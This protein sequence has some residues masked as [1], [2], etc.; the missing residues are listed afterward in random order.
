MKVIVFG[1]LAVAAIAQSHVIPLQ[2]VKTIVPV[3]AA[4]TLLRTPSLDSAVIS[5]ERLDGAF[6]Y[7]TVEN[8]AYTPVVYQS[9]SS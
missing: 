2:A 3:P 9:V 5:S 8:H 1:L 4:T 7:E 6:R